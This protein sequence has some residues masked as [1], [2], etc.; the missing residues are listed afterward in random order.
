MRAELRA[1]DPA[2]P[3]KLRTLSQVYS[4]S[5]APRRF[6]L[7]LLGAFASVA[8]LL[9][10]T[11]VTAYSVARRT[12]EIGVRVELGARPRAVVAMVVGQGVAMALVGVAIGLAAALALARLLASALYGVSATDP[13]TFAL[14]AFAVIGATLLA[15]YLPARRAA[16]IDPMVA[17]RTE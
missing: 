17:L 12:R 15:C 4:S 16:R 9:A 8:L 5:L 14:V 10:V 6:G 3:A 11:G 7:L 13:V 2:L 1:L